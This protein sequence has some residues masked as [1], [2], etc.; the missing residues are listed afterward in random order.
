[1]TNQTKTN[2]HILNPFLS[3][4]GGGI[5]EVIKELYN[6]DSFKYSSFSTSFWG[7]KDEY[8]AEDSTKLK[9]DKYL[10][11]IRCKFINKI[12]YSKELKKDF[13]SIVSSNDIIHLHSLWLF[14]SILAI[15]V[16]KKKCVKKII[17][18]HGM[19]DKWALHNGKIK[20]KLGLYFYEMK[21]LLT[22]DCIHALCEQEYTDI[23]KFSRKMPIAIIPNGINIPVN[24]TTRKKDSTKKSLLFLGRIHPKK[25][26]ENL[27]NAW[28]KI[29]HTNWTLIIAGPDEN[30]YLQKI[31]SLAKKLD[32]CESIQF[33]GP[34]FGEDKS[35]LF[36]N[37]DAFILP[38][39]SEG[40][41]MT[42]LEA[43]SFN[44]PVIM[45]PQ[46]NLPDGFTTNS[47]ISIEPNVE[48]II[49]GICRLFSMND[50]E[51]TE[52]SSNGFNLVQ[53]KYTWDSVANKMIMLYDW[54]TGKIEKPSFVRLD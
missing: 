50:R 34:K 11:K 20:K 40:L 38:S 2:V 3:R 32:I 25:G 16:Q 5:F 44:L 26:L 45:T 17:S 8:T 27:I 33:L 51:L 10:F 47:A 1:M 9:G 43:W 31:T 18:I 22:A 28:S 41:P 46:C 19:L 13:S 35:L 15:K 24:E 54:I 14:L 36:R 49:N 12:F 29:D 53:E 42:I 30:N 7:Y 52:M 4:S 39:F 48:G 21:N 23:R 6:S 37:S